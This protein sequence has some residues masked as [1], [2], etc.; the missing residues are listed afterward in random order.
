MMQKKTG[1]AV[2][3]GLSS[4]GASAFWAFIPDVLPMPVTIAGVSGGV[5]LMVLAG[6]LRLYDQRRAHRERGRVHLAK[7]VTEITCDRARSARYAEVWERAQ[8]SIYCFGVGMT[9]VARDTGPILAA[10]KKGRSVVFEM[11]DPLWLRAEPARQRDFED[12][13]GRPNFTDAV[14]HSL[15]QLV[16]LRDSLNTLYGANMVKI[17]VYQR[18]LHESGTIADP[19]TSDAWGYF[20]SHRPNFPFSQALMKVNMYESPSPVTEPAYVDSIVTARR[21]VPR[22]LVGGLASQRLPVP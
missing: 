10:V 5:T 19:Y 20:E 16:L 21:A 11:I 3:G 14:E 2:T 4:L 6:L 7:G 13:Y 17:I 1:L 8:S 22:N 15:S 9:N 12:W 18:Y